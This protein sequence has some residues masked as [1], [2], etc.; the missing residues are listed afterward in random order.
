MYYDT[1]RPWWTVEE[2]AALLRVNRKTLYE[3]CASD[4]FPCR[5]N[6]R[7]IRIPAEA[8]RL[9][10]KPS[11]RS[12]TYHVTDDVMQLELPLDVSMLVPVKR[13]RNTREV[14]QPWHY[15]DEKY[16]QKALRVPRKAV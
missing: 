16:S 1:D 5:R 15:E 7:Y 10:V 8:L 3:A 11:T 12:R 14:I 4:D 9:R 13:F 2:A 6:G